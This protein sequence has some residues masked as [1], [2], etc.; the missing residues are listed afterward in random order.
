MKE[1]PFMWQISLMN[2]TLGGLLETALEKIARNDNENLNKEIEQ[3]R[4]MYLEIIE[5]WDMDR[6]LIDD[7]DDKVKLPA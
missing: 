1:G 2:L 4:D 7:F 3:I 6:N 5:F